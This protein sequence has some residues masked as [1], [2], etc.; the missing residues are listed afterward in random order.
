MRGLSRPWLRPGV[1][2]STS[3]PEPERAGA[4]EDEVPR[5]RST[6]VRT[7]GFI[8]E[9]L[10]EHPLIG[11]VSSAPVIPRLSGL[12]TALPGLRA[13]AGILGGHWTAAASVTGVRHLQHGTTGQ[14]A[15]QVTA[16][17]DGTGLILVV[18]DGLGSKVE[19]AQIGAELLAR[20]AA[21]AAAALSGPDVAADPKAAL[22][23]VITTANDGVRRLRE[24]VLPEL[25]DRQ[26]SSTIIVCWVSMAPEWPEAYLAR[27]GDGNVFGA[28]GGGFFPFYPREDGAVNE[29]RD[30]LPRDEP[31]A[32]CEFLRI[33]TSEFA[34]L[35]AATDGLADDLFD[36]PQTRDW[37][38]VSWSVPCGAAR[39]LQTLRYRRATSHDDRTAAVLWLHPERY[40]DLEYRADGAEPARQDDHAPRAARTVVSTEDHAAPQISGD[41]AD[42]PVVDVPPREAV[43]AAAGG[44][45]PLPEN[46]SDELEPRPTDD[47]DHR[48]IR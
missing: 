48:Q 8:I 32:K 36:S 16:S 4:P 46:G 22:G 43:S 26:L 17:R 3:G 37:L 34:L 31:L 18:C 12:P 2:V 33:N 1:A 15:Y 42:V 40:A 14:D 45:A 10:P 7:G 9:E 29:V 20:R 30:S 24:C 35:L 5:E 11:R 19:T 13:D 47:G 25:A 27:V 41:R 44:A 6:A 28:R 39:M 21:Q 23:H 38:A